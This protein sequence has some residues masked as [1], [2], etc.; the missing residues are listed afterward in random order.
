MSR[1]SVFVF[2][3]DNK[4]DEIETEVLNTF[5]KLK[6]DTSIP[7]P[8]EGLIAKLKKIKKVKKY[9]KA[10]HI[11]VAYKCDKK[12]FESTKSFHHDIV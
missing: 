3:I 2:E 1:Q 12:L 5:K 6:V 10:V 9:R 4:G 11:M 7:L 8:W